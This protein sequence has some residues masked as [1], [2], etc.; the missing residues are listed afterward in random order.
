[1]VVDIA[2]G[3]VSPARPLIDPWPYIASATTRSYDVLADGGFI[4]VL[5]GQF[6]NEEEESIGWRERFR[7]S[8]LQVVLNFFEVLRQRVAN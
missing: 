8:E 3:R 6:G 1:M 7:V 5:R 4:A 2:E